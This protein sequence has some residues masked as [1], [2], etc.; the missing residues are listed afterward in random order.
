MINLLKALLYINSSFHVCRPTLLSAYL[1][2]NL[3]IGVDV[4]INMWRFKV[5]A[6]V[7]VYLF[8]NSLFNILFQTC[9]Y[10]VLQFSI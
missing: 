6:D 9:L 10:V 2:L 3:L 8:S 5:S 1:V 7:F 4:V